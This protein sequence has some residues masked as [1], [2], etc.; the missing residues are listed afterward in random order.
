MPKDVGDAD[1]WVG[2]GASAGGLEALRA[3][4]RNLPKDLRAT[5]IIAQHMAP[6]H[7][8]MLPEIIQRETDLEV[9]NVIDD[10]IPQPNKVYITPSNH[11]I[12]I[13][14]NRVRLVAPSEEP[15]SPK[16]SVDRFLATLAKAKGDHAIGIILSGTGSDGS[17]GIRHIRAGGGIT[18]AQDDMT[19]KYPS[20]PTSAV[21]TDCV[22][23]VMSPE[24]IGAQFANIVAEPRNLEALKSSPIHLDAL[25]ELFQ[26]LNMQ[27]GVNFRLYKSATVQRRV[28]RR[29]AA[30]RVSNLDDYVSIAKGSQREVQALFQ[31]LLIS[32]TSFF[33]DPGEFEALRPFIQQIVDAKRDSTAPIRIWIPG[34]ATGEEVYTIAFLFAEAFGGL[35]QFSRAR[36][37]IF[38]TDIDENA[39]EV[40]RRGFYSETALQE[41]PQE[42]VTRYFEP[43]MSGLTV[44]KALREKMVFS[45]HNVT[46]DPP[47][48]NIDLISCRNLLIYFQATLQAQ[49]LDRFH[50]ALVPNGVLFL[51]KSESVTASETL[52]RPAGTEKHIFFHRPAKHR[53][54]LPDLVD[55]PTHLQRRERSGSYV[56]A[57]DL[58]AAEARFTS[59]VAAVGPDA[60]LVTADLQVRQ[61]YGQMTPYINVR[62][63]N[64][65]TSVT[66]L[67]REPLGQDVRATVPVAIRKMQRS[68]CAAHIAPD[69]PNFRERVVIYPV[70]SGQGE[71][72]L[73]LVVFNRWKEEALVEREDYASESTERRIT[74][75]TQELN[76]AQTNLQQTVEE[77]ETSNEE[78]Q[79]LNEELQSSNEELQST[80]EE[81]ETSNEELQSTNEEL[82]TVNE[83]L[84]I[85]AQELQS[86]NESLRSILENVGIPMLV[87]DRSLVINSASR[88]A[89]EF[90]S[91]D[92]HFTHPHVSACSVPVGFPVLGTVLN[93]AIDTGLRIQRHVSSDTASAVL[94]VAPHFS[95]TGEI[96]GAIVLV[97]DNTE[98]LRRTRN[99][100]QTILDAMPEAIFVYSASGEVVSA[101][102]AGEAMIA[103]DDVSERLSGATQEEIRVS[104][105]KTIQSGAG[106]KARIR[107][108][109]MADGTKRWLQDSLVPGK[110]PAS[111]DSVAFGIAS[112]ITDLKEAEEV[113]RR[114]EA[115]LGMALEAAELAIWETDLE[116]GEIFWSDRYLDYAGLARDTPPDTWQDFLGRLHPEDYEVV[117]QALENPAPDQETLDVTFRLRHA[118]GHFVRM[119]ARAKWIRETGGKRVRLIGTMVD[120][121]RRDTTLE[122]LQEN[123]TQLQLAS[124]MAGL[125]YWKVDLMDNRLFWSDEI[126]SIHGV[127][128][129]GYTPDVDSA[130]NFY[131][132]DDIERIRGLVRH[133]VETGEAYEF[134]ARIVRPTGEVRSVHSI[135]TPR[136]GAGGAVVAVYGAFS[137]ITG[138]EE[139]EAQ[140]RE[141]ME[142]L[143]RS[144]EELNRFSYVCS[145][146]MKEPV[147][148]I[149]SM[150]ELLAEDGALE[151]DERTE[152]TGR[153]I[154]NTKRLR[155]I[156]DSL[157]AYSRTD[158]KVPA[159]DI[160][161]NEVLSEVS[162]TLSLAS[163]DRGA[164]I[165]VGP[166]P[167]IHGARLHFMQL[168][169]NLVGNAIKYNHTDKPRIVVSAALSDGTCLITVEDNGPGIPK[170]ERERIFQVFS[171]LNLRDEV[172]GVG[173]GLSICQRIVNQYGG[174]IQ[175]R[176]SQLGGAAFEFTLP[177]EETALWPTKPST[178][179]S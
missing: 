48:L 5:Y 24:E 85:N 13:A 137:D 172:D 154:R 41:I 170:A 122:T 155:S 45:H 132:P 120:L 38:A 163:A 46:Q 109:E 129:E 158:A 51:G 3:L 23:L 14:E 12:V 84:Q 98:E 113:L 6:H 125:G 145:H 157:L 79:A 179:S 70:E 136:R 58:Q 124:Q 139:R 19:A 59:L 100:L 69:D 106:H 118:N 34:S 63:G 119:A 147:R 159:A 146:D 161:L 115:R 102:I 20:M 47:F 30:V 67:V 17:Q 9:V 133:S 169:L 21:E 178:S 107:R 81:L 103:G 27:S 18:I 53:K 60:L 16:P 71:E 4:M 168:F 76:I 104:A 61:A 78:L 55:R 121:T 148:M 114:S 101:N 31:D 152:L 112:D 96:I 32:V 99:K 37:Q 141:A 28:E 26:L 80:N 142:D 156:I 93:E 131:H 25:S 73:A 75:L 10:L 126:F 49:V 77:L 62:Q 92:P 176:D 177:C 35:D 153:I 171:R 52:F 1:Y 95:N 160:D 166:M 123:T 135:G 39:I 82:S 74:A 15:S 50:Y 65:N 57:R 89:E 64:V 134:T 149:E 130:L 86:V 165:A 83:E 88:V 164:E 7:R 87:V 29:M 143:A 54:T 72:V 8:S 97:S 94:T 44:K 150:V 174:T 144:N 2:I 36:I 22:D 117:H 140:L 33:R 42:F 11:D 43:V 151:G 66:T 105:Q 108:A 90:F 128:R 40:A 91:L 110:D 175:C 173:L 167:I 162:D 68:A 116:T 127:T 138:Q 56:E 111:G